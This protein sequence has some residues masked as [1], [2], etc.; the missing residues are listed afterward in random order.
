MSEV[1]I[2]PTQANNDVG[3]IL[4]LLKQFFK[5]SESLQKVSLAEEIEAILNAITYSRFSPKKGKFYINVIA[6]KRDIILTV[7]SGESISDLTE[8]YDRTWVWRCKKELIAS[9]ILSEGND[10][11]LG[12]P[13]DKFPSIIFIQIIKGLGRLNNV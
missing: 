13:S 11:R 2:R 12:F 6:C 8:K 3:P 4:A 5:A 9:G 1:S 10:G 7:I